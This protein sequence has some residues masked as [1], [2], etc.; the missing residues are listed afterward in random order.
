M[1]TDLLTR[2][3][4]DT[5]ACETLLHFNNAGAALMPDPVFSVLTDYLEAER[6]MGGYEA[7]A[8]HAPQLDRFYTGF[9]ALLGVQAGEIAYAE[10]ATRAWDSVFY[11]LP[12]AEGDEVII[13]ASDYGSNTLSLMQMQARRGAARDRGPGMPVGWQRAD[14]RGRAG[15]D[16][17]RADAADLDQPYPHTGRHGEPGG[18]GGADC[19]GAGRSVPAGCLPKP[20]ADRRAR[21]GHRL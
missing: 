19:A 16:D 4:R 17:H 3:R 13:H 5:P 2:L 14:R 9:A 7:E 15:C 21:A 1:S 12:W 20:G 8:A 18:R 6:T 11:A 10:S